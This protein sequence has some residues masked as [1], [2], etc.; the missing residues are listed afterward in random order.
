MVE[1][2]LLQVLIY[3]RVDNIRHK[4]TSLMDW[5]FLDLESVSGVS[6]FETVLIWKPRNWYR[7][8]FVRLRPQ[9]HTKFM[10]KNIGE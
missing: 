9:N 4:R 3:R 1:C 10:R 8:T 5:V 7:Y 6:C 2:G